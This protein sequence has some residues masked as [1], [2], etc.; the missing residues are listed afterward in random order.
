M[1]NEIGD[2]PLVLRESAR[3]LRVLAD[4]FDEAADGTHDLDEL[5]SLVACTMPMVG[6]LASTAAEVQRL[7]E[8]TLITP[9]LAESLDARSRKGTARK[10]TARNCAKRRQAAS[11]VPTRRP[12]HG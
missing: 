10:D 3:A 6:A 12:N 9:K 7:T 1:S 8:P 2:T 11:A 5:A 4:R